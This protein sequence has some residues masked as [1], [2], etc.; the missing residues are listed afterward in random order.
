MQSPHVII[1]FKYEDKYFK[2]T[3]R[4]SDHIVQKWPSIWRSRNSIP[5]FKNNWPLNLWP[6]LPTVL[7]YKRT[8]SS[9]NMPRLS[10]VYARPA[11]FLF[12]SNICTNDIKLGYQKPAKL[13]KLF[14]HDDRMIRI[15]IHTSDYWIRIR[16]REA[17]KHM[18]SD[19]DPEH[20]WKQNFFDLLYLQIYVNKPTLCKNVESIHFLL[21][22]YL[23]IYVNIPASCKHVENVNF[24]T[25][26]YLRIYVKKNLTN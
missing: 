12:C 20:Y 2:A 26:L 3:W 5:Q 18:D 19:P 15:R 11:F 10:P 9:M 22:L 1:S 16:I 17:Q 7:N 4:Y 14:L 23:R 13:W 25:I 24:F 8:C 21:I 6:N